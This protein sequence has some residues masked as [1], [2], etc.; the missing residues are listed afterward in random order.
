MNLLRAKLIIPF[1]TSRKKTRYIFTSKLF[2]KKG[3]KSYSNY[4]YQN[5]YIINS[6][7][8]IFENIKKEDIEGYEMI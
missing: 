6:K 4:T 1:K 7:D 3:K 8:S 5:S 2:K